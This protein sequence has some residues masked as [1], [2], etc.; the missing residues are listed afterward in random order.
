MRQLYTI[1]YE[2]A[3]LEELIAA[4]KAEG[5]TRLLDIRYTPYSRRGEFSTDMLGAALQQYGIAYTHIRELGNPAKAREAALLGHK[6]AYRDLYTAHLQGPE[7][8]KGLRKARSFADS[9]TV[10]L[11][12]LERDPR[13]CHRSMTAGA[14]AAEGDFAVTHLKTSRKSPH[15]SQSMFEF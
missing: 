13:H 6:A 14:L 4:L 9:E 15:P 10:C 3:S 8:R 11:L 1:G 7:G 12:C 5:V 2:G